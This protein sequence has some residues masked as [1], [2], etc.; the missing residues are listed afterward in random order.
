MTVDELLTRDEEQSLLE[1]ACYHKQGYP[2]GVWAKLRRDSPIHHIES[3]TGP[4]WAVTLHK[5]I[6]AIETKPEIFKNGPRLTMAS[7]KKNDPPMVVDLDPPDHGLQRAVASKFFMPR[8]IVSLR[9]RTEEIVDEVFD[10]AMKRNG[11]I[12]DLQQDVSNLIPTAVVSAYLGAPREMWRPLNDWTSMI[13]NAADPLVSK[14]RSPQETIIYAHGEIYRAH[15]ETIADRRANPRDDFLSALIEAEIDGRKLTDKELL[16]WTGI[17][18]TAGHETTSSTFGMGVN[19]LLDHPDQLARLKADPGLLPKAIEEILR[20]TSPAI[21]FVRTPDRDVE[22]GGKHIRSGEQMVMF[23]PSANRDAE[24]FDEPDRFDIGRSPNKHLAFG[25][26]P[27]QC[28][29]MHLAKMELTVMF[30]QFLSRVETIERVAEPEHVFAVAT[31]GYRRL[32]VRMTIKPK[33][34]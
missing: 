18:S 24:A 32:P 26:G 2:W 27:H 19:T 13:F 1:P 14:D 7:H 12:I 25:C 30:E 21:H 23:Y 11:E 33:A 8:S 29:G 9:G 5:D 31:G 15:A 28:L 3:P 22:V 4:C 10:E 17:L 34:A 20:Y 6:L 16:G